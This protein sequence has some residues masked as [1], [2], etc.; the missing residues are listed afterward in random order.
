MVC[1]SVFAVLAIT[2]ALFLFRVRL[3]FIQIGFFLGNNRIATK[4]LTNVAVMIIGI[5]ILSSIIFMEDYLRNGVNKGIF[6]KRV[7]HIVIVEAVLFAL[8]MGLYYIFYLLTLK[9]AGL[10][11]LTLPWLVSLL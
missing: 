8:S 1:Y 7:V 3:N 11:F 5:V 4:G 10:S 6:W 9:E 2:A